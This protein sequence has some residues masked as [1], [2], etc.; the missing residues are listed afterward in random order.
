[1]TRYFC[2][3]DAMRLSRGDVAGLVEMLHAIPLPVHV[4]VADDF[5]LPAL[6]LELDA[7]STMRTQH[8]LARIN[9]SQ[10]SARLAR[11]CLF[12]HCNPLM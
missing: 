7:L 10:H 2:I 9:A 3:G 5:V 12:E 1:V 6:R 4:H 8:V 11:Q